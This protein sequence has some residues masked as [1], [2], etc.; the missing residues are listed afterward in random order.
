MAKIRARRNESGVGGDERGSILILG[1]IFLIVISMTIASLASWTM[2]DLNNTNAFT[3]ARATTYA[4]TSVVNVAVQSI[5]YAIDP[6]GRG[7][8]QNTVT[9]LGECWN[10]AAGGPAGVSQLTTDNVTVAVW[11]QTVENLNSPATRVVDLYACVST[12]TSASSTAI[13]NAAASDCQSSPRLHVEVTFDDYP[14][15]GSPPLTTQCTTWCG[16]G[17][18]LDTWVWG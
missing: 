11:C 17:T 10:P 8:T 16:D 2:N 13:I 12:L 9:A 5:R 6:T 4:S 18:S 14:P 3:N 15:G 7:F 1:M